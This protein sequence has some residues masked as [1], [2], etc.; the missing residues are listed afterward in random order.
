M[1]TLPPVTP[2]AVGQR[3]TFRAGLMSAAGGRAGRL[4]GV[5]LERHALHRG[6][7]RRPLGA[8]DSRSP[9]RRARSSLSAARLKSTREALHGRTVSTTRATS[10][11]TP[12]AR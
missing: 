6:A 2:T 1:L 12:N 7:E 10:S 9:G 5:C 4:D 8:V 11:S 3:N